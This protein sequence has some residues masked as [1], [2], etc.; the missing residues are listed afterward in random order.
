MD[1]S[2]IDDNVKRVFN[3]PLYLNGPELPISR[4]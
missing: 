4:G 3:K 1:L 2:F